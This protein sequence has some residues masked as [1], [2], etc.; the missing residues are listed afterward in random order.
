MNEWKRLEAAIGS[1]F[2]YR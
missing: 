1:V 2:S